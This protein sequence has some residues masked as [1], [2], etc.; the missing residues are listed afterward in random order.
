MAIVQSGGTLKTL[1]A[2]AAGPP[3]YDPYRASLSI[4]SPATYA[5][6]YRTQP[7]VR[8]VIEFLGWGIAGVDLHAYRR[9]SDLDRERLAGHELI[10]WLEHPNPATCYFRLIE[11]LVQDLCIYFNAAWMKV[12]DPNGSGRLALVRMPPGQITPNGWLLPTGYTWTLPN[13]EQIPLD[14][15]DLVWFNGYNPSDPLMGVSPLET[16][17]QRLLEDCAATAFR[18]AYWLNS[19]RLEG[20]IT[21]PKDAPRWTPEQKQAFREQWIARHTGAANAGSVAVLEDGMGFTPTS[22]SARESE[23]TA[24][25]KLTREEVTNE[26]HVPQPSVGILDHATFSNIKEQ[27]K[28]L[29]QD[30]FSPW[31]KWISQELERQLLPECRDR[32]GVYLEFN[33]N[34][35]LK[36]SFEEQASSLYTMCGRPIMTANEGR[37]R[38]NLPRITDD[39]SAD[40]LAMPLNTGAGGQNLPPAPTDDAPP[41]RPERPDVDPDAIAPVVMRA[42]VRQR[43]R[44]E[45]LPIEDRP[46][47]FTPIDRWD[48]ELAE[49]LVPLYRAAGLDYATALKR[50]EALACRVNTETLRRLIDGADAFSNREVGLV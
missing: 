45:K 22:Y 8:T 49:S 4:A 6:I 31:F 39:E 23:F 27:H 40:Q 18:R 26:Y 48:R 10:D 47:A 14:L 13:G 42:W 29:Y 46:A 17:R 32:Q 20:V 50:S 35:K 38:L 44:L 1:D 37:A 15:G 33:I 30:T 28:Q 24:A 34:E 36:G 25:R 9:V 12:R 5:E 21:R 2:I 7:A 19:S 3:A 41:P 11:S 43:A 16:L